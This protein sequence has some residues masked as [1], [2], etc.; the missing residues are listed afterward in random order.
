[1]NNALSYDEVIKKLETEGKVLKSLKP[2]SCS[3]ICIL[4]VPL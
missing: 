3:T 2:W 4:L 1:M